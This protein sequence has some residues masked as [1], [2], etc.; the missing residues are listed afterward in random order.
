VSVFACMYECLF[1]RPF[2]LFII[3]DIVGLFGQE[4]FDYSIGQPA[5]MF[6]WVLQEV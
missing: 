1:A 4:M 5:M 2:L 3:K 6:V